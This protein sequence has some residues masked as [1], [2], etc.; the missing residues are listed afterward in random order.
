MAEERNAAVVR[1]AIEE[2]WTRGQLEV[3][4][5]LFAPTYV[6]H[7]GL[8]PDLVRGPEAIKIGVVLF[9]TGFPTLRI[10]IERLVAE[11]ELV[12]VHWAAHHTPTAS[13]VVSAGASR[14]ERFTGTTLSRLAEGQIVESWTTWDRQGVLQELGIVHPTTPT[15]APPGST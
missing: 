10:A 5:L 6:N 1:R 7:S 14:R 13:Q 12:E 4:D 3:A 11:G 2:V 9:R 8:I 15:D